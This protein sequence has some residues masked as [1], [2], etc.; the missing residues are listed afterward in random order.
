MKTIALVL[1]LTITAPLA[2]TACDRTVA[3]DTKTTSTDNGT[4]TETKEV[5][6]SPNGDVTVTKE[7]STSS[8]N[9]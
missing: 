6:Q 5:T 1:A 3:T 4:K 8:N 9:P 7:K 2:F